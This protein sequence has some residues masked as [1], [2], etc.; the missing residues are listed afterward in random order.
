MGTSA[1]WVPRTL[2]GQTPQPSLEGLKVISTPLL[3]LPLDSFFFSKLPQIVHSDREDVKWHLNPLCNG[4]AFEL[5]CREK[6]LSSGELGI[7]PNL[8]IADAE[9]IRSFLSASHVRK[10]A[11]SSTD[12]EDLYQ[13]IGSDPEMARLEKVHTSTSKKVRRILKV[14]DRRSPLVN[15]ARTGRV[16]AS[17]I[18]I[19]KSAR[20]THSRYRQSERKC[21]PSLERKTSLSSSHFCWTRLIPGLQHIV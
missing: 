4:C 21:S 9:L 15:A 12:I 18:T 10:L 6:A 13:T 20:R 3:A 8:S 17:F 14:K 16:Q 5:N 2:Q 1:V 19:A 7:I 11:I